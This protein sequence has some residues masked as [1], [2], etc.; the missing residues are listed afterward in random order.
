MVW[1]ILRRFAPETIVG[2]IM[3]MRALNDMAGAVFDVPEDKA[4]QF[5]D[6][7]KHAKESGTRMDFDI[8]KCKALPDLLDKDFGRGA[9]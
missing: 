4:T 6:I 7:F 3:G 2:E 5:E 9:H 8:N 1:N